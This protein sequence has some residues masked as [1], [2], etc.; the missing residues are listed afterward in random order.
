MELLGWMAPVISNEIT[1]YAV[2]GALLAWALVSAAFL[3]VG[4]WRFK[5]AVQRFYRS[6]GRY[7]DAPAFA[8]GFERASAEL[9]RQRFL[10]EPWRQF[11]Q[12]L[13]L[14]RRPGEPIRATQRPAEWFNVGLLRGPGLGV[15]LRYHAAM[16][17]LLVGAG[18]LFTFLG[19]AVALAGAKDIV[20][21]ETLARNEAL[22]TLLAT[23]SFKFITSLVGMLLSILYALFR[24]SRLHRVERTLDGLQASI[25]K[26]MPVVSPLALQQEQLALLER[27]TNQLETFSNDLAVSI[28]SQIDQTFNE[29]LAE[30]IGPL[31]EAIQQLSAG[32]GTR[33]EDALRE[34]MAA[35]LAQLEGEAGGRMD[36]VART[37][38]GLVGG[39]ERLQTGLDAASERMARA[40]DE[41]AARMGGQ[42][43]ATAERLNTQLAAMVAELR[44]LASTSRD[45]GNLAIEELA[46]RIAAAAG[47]FESAAERIAE[48]LKRAA[49]DT[50]AM[51]DKGAEAMVERMVAATEG[52]RE[53]MRRVLDE[54]RRSV[55][56]VSEDLSK[57]GDAAAISIKMSVDAASQALAT[58]LGNAAGQ[59][60]SAGDEAGSALQRGGEG[61]AGM[62]ERAGGAFGNRADALALS[63]GQLA[64]AAG[65]LV[66]RVKELEQAMGKAAAPL[67]TSAAEL[68]TASR[69]THELMAHL[70]QATR[71]IAGAVDQISGTA[72]RLES[73]AGSASKLATSLDSATQRFEGIDRDLAQTL[74]GLQSGLKGFAQET[75][76][77]VRDIDKGLAG[78][79][80][81]L[82]ALVKE[83]GEMIEDLEAN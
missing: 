3:V 73:A 28:G 5:A 13:L 32:M 31:T 2:C 53:E 51:F 16:P 8:N 6:L 24:K 74:Q 47:S 35:F 7:A 60:A 68:A 83:L 69:S 11:R 63:S 48:G 76:T 80:Q 12:T 65:G 9:E 44:A 25:E 59:L 45:A 72:Q 19:L 1:I 23:A 38:M 57:G 71:G 39:L 20:T 4:T 17:N 41:M 43:E 46:G 55:A 78:A 52:I 30:H 66:Q 33:N 36:E 14:P 27:Q 29:R 49:T 67:Q 22:R 54:L 75:A 64:D 34:M 61:A 70:A 62:L 77:F 26:L 56:T 42:A 40:A 81:R 15:D 79:V 58:A 37:L 82:A 10:G 50:G 18:L 21:G